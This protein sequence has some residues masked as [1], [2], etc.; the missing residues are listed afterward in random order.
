MFPLAQKLLGQ[1]HVTRLIVGDDAAFGTSLGE[2]IPED[3]P[4]LI[5]IA[6][7]LTAPTPK[8]W[9]AIQPDALAVLQY[10]GGTTGL[11]KAAMH[12]PRQS[13]RRGRHLPPVLHHAER[14]PERAGARHRRPA[15]LPHLRPRRTA[16]LA[17]ATRRHP[18][19]AQAFRCRSHP[20]RHRGQ[21]RHLFPRRSHHVDRA[22]RAPRYRDTGFLIAPPNLLRR[23]ATAAGRRRARQNHDRPAHRR[24]LGHDRNRRRRRVAPHAGPL[25]PQF[26]RCSAPRRA[27]PDRRPGRSHQNPRPQRDRRNR[28]NTAPIF[29]KATGKTPRKRNAPS[30][31]PASS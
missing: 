29:S 15:L 17:A 3:Q 28:H 6:D 25:R 24:R 16:A 1:G 8:S 4:G 20:A 9:P 2:P 21:T 19:P 5:N 14:P 11:P 7:L 18:A 27:N 12:S 31:H 26:R 23:R 13:A 22:E 10:T 30:L